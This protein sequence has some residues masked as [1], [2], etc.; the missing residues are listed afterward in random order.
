MANKTTAASKKKTSK[1]KTKASAGI[2]SG[3]RFEVVSLSIVEPTLKRA[4]AKGAR[5]CSGGG[6]CIALV[7]ISSK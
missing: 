6:T 7:D 5:L 3:M 4:R 1:T 2:K